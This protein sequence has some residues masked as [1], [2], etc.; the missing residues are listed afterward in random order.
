MSKT[1]DFKIIIVFLFLVSIVFA[2]CAPKAKPTE[3]EVPVAEET[4]SVV[5][6][7]YTPVVIMIRTG[8]E[9]DA[10]RAVA[11]AY[12]EETGKKIEVNEQGRAGYFD[13][14][15]TR[16]LAGTPDI[17]LIFFPSTYVAQFAE[18]GTLEPLDKYMKDAE[19]TDPAVFDIDD[20]LAVYGYKGSTYA[21]PTDVSA[22]FLFYREDLIPDPPQTWDE[23][24][25]VARKYT[26]ALNPDSPTIW[27]ASFDALAPEEGPK[28][29]YD[30]MWS[31]GGFL[32]DEDGNV[33]VNNEGAVKAM[34]IWKTM[35]DEGLISPET[36]NWGFSEVLD[37]LTSGTVAMGSP[38]WNA[39]YDPILNSGTP[40]SKTV[41]ITLVPGVKQDDGSILRTPFQHGW[42]LVMNQASENK[43]EAW[44]F[45]EWATG[46]K[47]GTIHAKHGGTPARASILNDPQF[48]DTRPDFALMVETLKIARG[49]PAVVFYDEMHEAMNIA[50]AH[51]LSDGWEPKDALDEAAATIKQLIEDNK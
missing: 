46:K 3:A 34:N 36:N 32:I 9:A 22:H 19:L 47:G 28:I 11:E 29:F 21:L 37:A 41:K 23:V 1:K 44:K 18:A 35:I 51:V 39:A 20:F 43:V 15:S 13:A 12:E 26:K 31:Y 30:L 45:L 8:D 25:E 7:E 50:I 17:D 40:Q 33:G 6:E 48:A 27:G 14:L 10:L 4:E 24:L 38:F 5:E 42:T 2:S 49:E 16:L